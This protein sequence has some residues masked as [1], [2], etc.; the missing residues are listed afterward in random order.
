MYELVRAA[1]YV[2]LE[3]TEATP[4]PRLSSRSSSR[5]A[6]DRSGGVAARFEG[7]AD[8]ERQSSR[9][10]TQLQR[11]M[12][13]LPLEM[14]GAR[15]AMVTFTYPGDWQRWCPNGR[16]LERHR[17]LMRRRWEARWEPLV[18]VW[19]KEFQ[20]RGAP[21]LHWYV[22]LPGAM[23]A[24]D[25]AALQARTRA[26]FGWEQAYG[27][28]G[29]RG[30]GRAIGKGGRGEDYGGEFANWLRT[31][32]AE[33]VTGNTVPA[34][35]VRGVDVKVMFLTDDEAAHR[36]RIQVAAYLAAEAGKRSQKMAPP[37]FVGVGQ[38]YGWF[39]RQLG[40]VPQ[41][42]RLVVDDAVARQVELRLERWLRVRA[43]VG[44]G[45]IAT[46]GRGRVGWLDRRRAGDGLTVERVANGFEQG[47]RL[48]ARAER[49][50]GTASGERAWRRWRE[51]AWARQEAWRVG[52]GRGPSLA[53]AGGAAPP[54]PGVAAC[55]CA[56]VDVG[57]EEWRDDGDGPLFGWAEEWVAA[58][59]A[60][61]TCE[62]R[63][64]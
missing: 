36:S 1:G 41:V 2:R 8:V 32:W 46:A 55:G 29:G 26:G 25:F 43:A 50:A 7:R 14:L 31:A 63:R 9:S 57:R 18:G 15:A 37:G 19:V 64:A 3:R 17:D 48:L 61:A 22:A 58:C 13:A 20:Q 12:L 53:A 10:R 11:L 47:L 21:H 49:A 28:R 42:E 59:V 54:S 52:A 16:A 51:R 27:R 45:R 5:G 56:F 62:G 33:I 24:E 30:R 35:H 40:F 6:G 44:R 34:H 39:G 38:W 60:G 4:R 23:P